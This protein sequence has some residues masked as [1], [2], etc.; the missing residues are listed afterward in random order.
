MN[1]DNSFHKYMKYKKKYLSLKNKIQHGGNR[2]KIIKYSSSTCS[3]LHMSPGCGS[4]DF[5]LYTDDTTEYSKTDWKTKETTIKK[6]NI[7]KQEYDNVVNAIHSD[8]F[9][10]YDDVP[11]PKMLAYDGP[12]RSITFYTN[13]GIEKQIDITTLG[14]I[15]PT[16]INYLKNVVDKVLSI[17]DSCRK[18][19][20]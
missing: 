2:R 10:K 17:M 14:T 20:T 5:T 15:N 4:Y 18:T 19:S 1:V 8:D 3:P 11:Y 13:D 7:S 9:M 16:H 12:G 6:Y